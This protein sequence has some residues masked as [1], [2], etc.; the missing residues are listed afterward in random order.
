MIYD[1]YFGS[2]YSNPEWDKQSN[3]TI[4]EFKTISEFNQIR[5][6]DFNAPYEQF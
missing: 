6:K 1:A 4:I 2:E 3:D 5:G